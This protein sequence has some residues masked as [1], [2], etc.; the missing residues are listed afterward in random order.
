MNNLQTYLGIYLEVPIKKTT[1]T[2]TVYYD[3]KGHLTAYK[4]DPL[5]GESNISKPKVISKVVY[6]SYVDL[7]DKSIED[8]EYLGLNVDSFMSPE[9]TSSNIFLLIPNGINY[10]PFAI[11]EDSCIVDLSKVE[12]SQEISKFKTD[13]QKIISFLETK[14]GKIKIK[15]GLL[16]F[17]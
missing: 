3:S 17:F 1:E 6:G 12:I 5:T 14:C 2:I 11:S 10:N 13:Y 8:F 15:L 9:S 4:F 16:N 7:F